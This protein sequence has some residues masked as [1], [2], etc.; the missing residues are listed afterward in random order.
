MSV[1]VVQDLA[2]DH[3]PASLR[4]SLSRTELLTAACEA[5]GVE[6]AQL[7]QVVTLERL[8][9]RLGLNVTASFAE[10]LLLAGAL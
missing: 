6:Q 1:A 4:T 10:R 3:V 5:A 7:G 8:N 2:V 9:A